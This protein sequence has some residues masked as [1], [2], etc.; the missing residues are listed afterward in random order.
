MKADGDALAV[1]SP[2][3]DGHVWS[4]RP[5]EPIE[6]LIEAREVAELQHAE[7]TCMHMGR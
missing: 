5:H 7:V 6:A 2:H 1:L 4:H 3:L